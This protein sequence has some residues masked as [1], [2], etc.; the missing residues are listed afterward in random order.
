MPASLLILMCS[1]A[2]LYGAENVSEVYY[3]NIKGVNHTAVGINWFSY[4]GQRGAGVRPFGESGY[5]CCAAVLAKWRPG[6]KA[7]IEWEVDPNPDADIPMRKEGFGFEKGAWEAHA[8][9][10]EMYRVVLDVPEYGDSFCGPTV[11]F[12]T[13]RRVKITHSCA[14]YWSPRHPIKEPLEME[15]PAVC[16]EN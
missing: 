1:S 14:A 13:C 12:L 4:S 5:S 11:H 16:P 9:N 3:G 10:F 6:L 15:E 7:T 2:N 8:K